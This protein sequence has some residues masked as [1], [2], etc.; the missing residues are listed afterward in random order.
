MQNRENIFRAGKRADKEKKFI[1]RVVGVGIK[2]G[3]NL[4][5]KQDMEQLR[6][7]KPKSVYDMT[8]GIGGYPQ[9]RYGQNKQTKNV[10]RF[11]STTTFVYNR[12]KETKVVEQRQSFIDK[13]KE[14]SR[15]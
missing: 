13:E 6:E 3:K 2:S 10:R 5:E 11:A 15:L 9:K 14:E 12:I 1:H 4:Q 8:K 7:E